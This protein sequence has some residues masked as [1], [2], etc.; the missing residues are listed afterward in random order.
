VADQNKIK[1]MAKWNNNFQDEGS[2]DKSS[3]SSEDEKTKEDAAKINVIKDN[4]KKIFDIESETKFSDQHLSS[5][6]LFKSISKEDHKTSSDEKMTSSLSPKEQSQIIKREESMETITEKKGEYEEKEKE[7]A[8]KLPHSTSLGKSMENREPILEIEEKPQE[9][10]ET[11]DKHHEDKEG[12][13]FF[14]RQLKKTSEVDDMH[15][16]KIISNSIQLGDTCKHSQMIL[17]DIKNDTLNKGKFSFSK[18]F[19]LR[20]FMGMFGGS[21]RNKTVTTFKNYKHSRCFNQKG[22][23]THLKSQRLELR[24]FS[25]EPGLPAPLPPQTIRTL[26]DSVPNRLK[27]LLQFHSKMRVLLLSTWKPLS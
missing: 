3:Y 9:E 5:K 16:F 6:A 15:S 10:T 27:N 2:Q 23:R 18:L 14:E 21:N 20:R 1:E 13:V 24:R 7:R 17:Q 8:H 26:L 11:E 19:G 25:R 12:Q 4:D 22:K